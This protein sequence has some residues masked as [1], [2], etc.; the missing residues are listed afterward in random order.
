VRSL[1][2]ENRAT[3]KAYDKTEDDLKALQ[4]MGQIIG[5]VLKQLDEERCECPI[6]NTSARSRECGGSLGARFLDAARASPASLIRARSRTS[7]SLSGRSPGASPRAWQ[8]SLAT[9]TTS[10]NSSPFQQLP[11]SPHT[12][13]EK[14]I[15]VSFVSLPRAHWTNRLTNLPTTDPP[16]AARRSHREGIERPAVHSGVPHEARQG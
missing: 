3:K 10:R 15:C 1:R 7:N 6:P 5:E 2:E 14:R 11:I 16:S 8:P 12:T 13:H 9:H 4:S